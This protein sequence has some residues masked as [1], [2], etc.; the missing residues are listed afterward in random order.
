MVSFLCFRCVVV[1]GC[2]PNQHIR[3]L[4]LSKELHLSEELRLSEELYLF[5]H[6]RPVRLS[7]V[8]L[9]RARPSLVQLPKLDCHST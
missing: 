7:L 9:P 8:Q 2:F 4:H 5:A 3:S 6:N 1:S